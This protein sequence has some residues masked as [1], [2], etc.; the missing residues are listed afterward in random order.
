MNPYCAKHEWPAG[1]GK[2]CPDCEELNAL[3][4]QIREAERLAM[5][6]KEAADRANAQLRDFKMEFEQQDMALTNALNDLAAANRLNGEL[7]RIYKEM[8]EQFCLQQGSFN[9]WHGKL[10]DVLTKSERPIDLSCGCEHPATI[11]CDCACHAIKRV[12][13]G[14]NG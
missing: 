10:L 8:L 13:G 5:V 1:M 2:P 14:Q 4:L 12:E 6:S 3:K 9:Y 7:Q 11:N